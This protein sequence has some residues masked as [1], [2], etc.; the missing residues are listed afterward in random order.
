MARLKNFPPKIAQDMPR[1]RQT[2]TGVAITPSVQLLNPVP[3]AELPE[4]DHTMPLPPARPGS[5][6]AASTASRK[7]A[8]STWSNRRNQPDHRGHKRISGAKASG[9]GSRDTKHSGEGERVGA[10]E[11]TRTSTGVT[12]QRPQR[13]ASTIPPRPHASRLV[14]GL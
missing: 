8:T 7:R 2:R 13:C 12:P 6:R 11:K 5:G 10:A 9:T 4:E 14:S 3:C 1:R